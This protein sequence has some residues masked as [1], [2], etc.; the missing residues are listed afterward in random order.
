MIEII[1]A[2]NSKK[3]NEELKKE[4]NISIIGNDIQYKEAIIEM[5]EKNKEIK[6]ILLY[7]KILGQISIEELILKIKKIN[8]NIN[9][10]FF[11]EKNDEKKIKILNKYNIKNIYLKN[12]IKKEF[13]INLLNNKIK[14]NNK[15]SEINNKKIIKN[16]INKLINKNK[17]KKIVFIGNNKKIINN[18]LIKIINKI[19]KKIIIINLNK[20]NKNILKEINKI[21]KN[22]I[23]RV[24]SSL[25]V[26]I[27]A[28]LVYF[29]GIKKINNAI[30][31]PY[32]ILMI[33]L[34]FFVDISLNRIIA[35]KLKK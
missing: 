28:V 19:N 9:I 6:I 1:T 27:I 33:I 21:Y 26:V 20:N 10:I 14:N 17:I 8:K 32:S 29:I 35:K 7:E 11:L 22:K 15:K 4:K 31:H 2:I 25:F 23:L 30:L 18:I 24:L 3:I 13:I 16:K 5:L 12:K 34:G